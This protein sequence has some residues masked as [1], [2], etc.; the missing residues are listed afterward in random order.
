M[1]GCAILIVRCMS[2]DH[3]ETGKCA[4][5]GA[6]FLYLPG[7][8]CTSCR[9]FPLRAESEQKLWIETLTETHSMYLIRLSI[10]NSTKSERPGLAPALFTCQPRYMAERELLYPVGLISRSYLP[11]SFA[12]TASI[13]QCKLKIVNFLNCGARQ[14]A[15]IRMP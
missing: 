3:M 2:D 6:I 13:L 7:N 11:F 8:L 14:I 4:P 10:E 1:D 9:M 5:I 15:T 12:H